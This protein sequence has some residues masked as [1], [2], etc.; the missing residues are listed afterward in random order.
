MRLGY[1]AIFVLVFS[2]VLTLSVRAEMA[3]QLVPV[4]T[5]LLDGTRLQLL[6]AKS[7]VDLPGAGWKWMTY[8]GAGRNFF[9]VNNTGQSYLVAAGEL[10]GDFTDHQPTSLITNAKKAIEARGGKLEADK[11]EWVEIP[12][13][14]KCV[15]VTFVEVEKPGTKSLV[16]LY[17][18]QTVGSSSVK[19][20][21]NGTAGV[22]AEPE[23]FKALAKSLK[24]VAEKK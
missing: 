16:I 7:T 19:V 13:I 20:Q 11:F 8:P 12:G 17:I 6:N 22:T 2:T 21:F 4:D 1:R 10:H 3:A 14:S 15:R 24:L 18:A 5:K 23:A 9:C